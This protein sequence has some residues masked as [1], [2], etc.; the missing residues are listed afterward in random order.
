MNLLRYGLTLLFGACGFLSAFNTLRAQT[1]ADSIAVVSAQ[2]QTTQIADGLVSRSAFMADLYGGAQTIDVVEV[3]TKKGFKLGIA[4][5]PT[6]RPT[7]RQAADHDAVAAINGSFYNMKQGNSVCYYRVGHT[8]VDTTTSREFSRRITGAIRERGG[9][10]ELLPWNRQVEQRYS[11]RR[12]TVLAAGP[13]L[14][15]EGCMADWSRCD[16]AF[17]A[18]KHPRSAIGCTSD[19]RIMLVAVNGRFAGKSEGMSIPELAHLMHLLGCVDA[20]NLDGGGSTTLWTEKD[21]VINYPSDN[22]K[23]DH[24]GERSVANIIYVYR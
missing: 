2:W 12:G 16:S 1:L 7:S 21:G 13:L 19:G 17:V 14:I 24:E 5:E 9:Q 20:L 6:M 4:A 18:A 10:L 8:V 15:A 22:R 11:R 3:V 23:F